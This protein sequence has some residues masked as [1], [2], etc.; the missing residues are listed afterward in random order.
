M[1]Q[2]LAQIGTEKNNTLIVPIPVDLIRSIL[3]G[4]APDT[5]K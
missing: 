2:T 4:V 3:R 5:K 1:L